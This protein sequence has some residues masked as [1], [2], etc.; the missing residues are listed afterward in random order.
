MLRKAALA[1]ILV[2]AIVGVAAVVSFLT[3]PATQ[4]ESGTSITEFTVNNMDCEVENCIV[5]SGAPMVLSVGIQS[6]E[7]IENLEVHVW[8][9]WS[10][11]YNK[12]EIDE[13]RVVS[14]EAGEHRVENFKTTAFCSPCAQIN[15]GP[16]EIHAKISFQGDVFDESEM[17]IYL[18]E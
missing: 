5:M 1:G 8:G 2:A 3:Q 15:P 12:Y 4:S 17:T 10:P 18:T 13:S 14:F 9:I 11:R 7:T 16:H 6:S